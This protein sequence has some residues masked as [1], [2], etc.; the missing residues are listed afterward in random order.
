[1][2]VEKQVRQKMGSVDPCEV[3]DTI[4][5]RSDGCE[6]NEF[7]LEPKVKRHK[8]RLS[9]SQLGKKAWKTLGLIA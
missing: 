4:D 1:M 5:T 9:S 3:D 6:A 2:A 8:F 7:S